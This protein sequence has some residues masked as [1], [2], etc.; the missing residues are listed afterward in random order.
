MKNKCLVV[1]SGGQDS[2]TCLFIAKKDYDEVHAITFDYGQRHHIEIE[3][4]KIVAEMAG[5]ASHEIIEVPNCLKSSSPLT[6][7]ANLEQY[8]DA[9]QMDAIIGNRIE[10]TFVSMRNALFLTIAANRA[11][12]LG[13]T[14]IVTGV[15]EA[16]NANY[17]DCRANFVEAT[18]HYIN[19]ALGNDLLTRGDWIDIDAPL[20]FSSKA[21]SIRHAMD[22]QGCMEALAYSHT[23]YDGKYPP[24]DMN[25][26]NVL[27][28][29]GFEEAGVPDPLVLRA[30]SEG[31]M[32][33]P[34]TANYQGL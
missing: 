33:L 12:A 2:T 28:A 17:P 25:H 27:R 11:Y 23:S 18:E 10:T 31:L 15:C 21:D 26:A 34:N 22:L 13:C 8:T 16:D 20:L 14:S 3:S 30:V 9:A 24:T 19:L 6:S 4:A 1:L 29:A 7:N 5:V 32:E